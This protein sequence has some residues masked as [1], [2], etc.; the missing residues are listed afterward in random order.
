MDDK[1]EINIFENRIKFV[2]EKYKLNMRNIRNIFYTKQTPTYGAHLISMLIC[3]ALI[4]YTFLIIT[5]SIEY[6][7]TF[8]TIIIILYPVS[9]YLTGSDWIM[10]EYRDH[11][12]LKRAYFSD[13]SLPEGSVLRGV[14]SSKD[15]GS[16]YK[17]FQLVHTDKNY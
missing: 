15:P 16:L 9:L 2:G 4:W 7:L 14:D 6:F 17:K 12:S 5:Y 1:G 13:G 8:F 3:I 11:G 10:I